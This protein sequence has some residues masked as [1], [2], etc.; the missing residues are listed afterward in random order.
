MRLD[1]AKNSAGYMPQ[2]LK[3]L[4]K[5]CIFVCKIFKCIN[6]IDHTAPIFL[7]REILV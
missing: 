2:L 1:S 7:Q 5:K 6:E 3:D 4:L